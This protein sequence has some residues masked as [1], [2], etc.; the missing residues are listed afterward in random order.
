MV[1]VCHAFFCKDP[2]GLGK[3]VNS[4]LT[5]FKGAVNTLRQHSKKSY[6]INAVSDMMM[7]MQVMNNERQP[8]D[9]QLVSALA[10]QVQRNS[11]LLKSI[12][13]SHFVGSKI[14][15]FGAS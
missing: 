12:I 10:Q 3:L 11:Q 13:K 1:T 4:P 2:E 14:L 8:I 6:H 9:H 15:R 5:K 7:F